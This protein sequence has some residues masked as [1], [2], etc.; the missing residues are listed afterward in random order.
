[1]HQHTQ[2]IVKDLLLIDFEER[3]NN[4]TELIY[5]HTLIALKNYFMDSPITEKIGFLDRRETFEIDV[6]S[7]EE[8]SSTITIDYPI[9]YECLLACKGKL[10]LCGVELV[11]IMNGDVVNSFN[12][13]FDSCTISEANSYVDKCS[14][15]FKNSYFI[16]SFGNNSLIFTDKDNNVVRIYF[17]IFENKNMLLR[18]IG[19]VPER[20]G[21]NPIDGYFGTLSGSMSIIMAAYLIDSR[22]IFRKFQHYLEDIGYIILFPGFNENFD[23]TVLN[24][25]ENITS[26]I[27]EY[28][29]KDGIHSTIIGVDTYNSIITAIDNNQNSTETYSSPSFS[30]FQENYSRTSNLKEL[31]GDLYKVNIVGIDNDRYVA[32]SGCKRKFNLNNDIFQLICKYWVHAEAQT[33]KGRLLNFNEIGATA[34]NY[35]SNLKDSDFLKR[36][37]LQLEEYTRAIVTNP[38][39][40][41]FNYKIDHPQYLIQQLGKVIPQYMPGLTYMSLEEFTSKIIHDLLSN[42]GRFTTISTPWTIELAKQSA[43]LIHILG[44]VRTKL[45]IIVCLNEVKTYEHCLSEELTVGILLGIYGCK[46]IVLYLKELPYVS[47]LLEDLIINYVGESKNYGMI[48]SNPVSYEQLYISFD[49]PELIQGVITGATW[50]NRNPRDLIT[51]LTRI[52]IDREHIPITF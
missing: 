1:M 37:K 18:N 49:N 43:N 19:D 47:L 3:V 8:L 41:L 24:F 33:A 46:N 40:D 23:S 31:F 39:K 51:N 35:S 16:S 2:R 25:D 30:Y 52:N 29:G 12:L 26:N 10:S 42:A 14:S 34:F 27:I 22:F 9:I 32:F 17:T 38:A 45:S 13:F 4:S 28:E 21:W 5:S 48:Y 11:T 6:E 50:V 36:N 20:H 44:A 15:I 7:I